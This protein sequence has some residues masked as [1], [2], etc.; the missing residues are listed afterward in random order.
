VTTENRNDPPE[1]PDSRLYTFIDGSREFALA[2]FEGQRL[3]RDLALLHPIRGRGFAYFRDVVLSVQPMITLLK[4]GEQFGFYIDSI[5]PRFRLKIETEHAGDTR[6]VLVPEQFGEFPE[7]MRGIVRLLK[8][9]PGNRPPYESVLKAEDLPLREIVNRVLADSFQT[10]STVKLSQESDQ[11]LI[12][13]RLPPLAGK[14][15]YDY[16]P[17]AVLAR[18]DE[19]EEELERIFDLALTRHEDVRDAFAR[20]GFRLLASRAVRFRCNCSHQRMVHNVKLLGDEAVA[21]LFDPGQEALEITC[22]YCKSVYRLTRTDL[23]ES[24]GRPH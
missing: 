13:H 21:G 5:E 10:P 12:L 24:A 11:S 16:S 7:A 1:L 18:R 6:S 8:L 14:D 17:Q 20:I 19:I 3:I 2:F 4:T 23:G 22:E 9:F 15:E